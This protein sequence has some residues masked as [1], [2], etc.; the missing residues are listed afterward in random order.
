M[1]VGMC[2][3]VP[4]ISVGPITDA[5]SMLPHVMQK[6][7]S[8][9]V[10]VHGGEVILGFSSPRKDGDLARHIHARQVVARVGLG[11]A[12]LLGLGDHRAEGRAA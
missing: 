10:P 12:Q 11:V 8:S 7:Q 5:C 4:E 2:S 3:A 9:D 1:A 6:C